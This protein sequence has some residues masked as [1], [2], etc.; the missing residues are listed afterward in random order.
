MRELGGRWRPLKADHHHART[1]GI[2]LDQGAGQRRRRIVIGQWRR[3]DRVSIPLRDRAR[4]VGESILNALAAGAAAALHPSLDRILGNL[5]A[6]EAERGTAAL[7]AAPAHHWPIIMAH[8]VVAT[9]AMQAAMPTTSGAHGCTSSCRAN[10]RLTAGH[11]AAGA[12]AT[13][14]AR[15]RHAQGE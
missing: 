13:R 14:Y 4:R 12:A 11:L 1:L 2:A 6:F 7:R 10:S 15:Q 5:V 3:L 8:R 9:P